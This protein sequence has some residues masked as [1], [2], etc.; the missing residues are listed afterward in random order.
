[1]F[2][3]PA[4]RAETHLKIEA[5]A[6]SLMMYGPAPTIL[7]S[8]SD[9]SQ[10][11][12]IQ[13]ATDASVVYSEVIAFG[14]LA[15]GEHVAFRR[16]HTDLSVSV[17]GAPVYH[18]RFVLC[19]GSGAALEGELAGHGVMGTLV[20]ISGD[21]GLVAYVRHGLTRSEIHGGASGLPGGV[22]CIVKVL[23][24]TLQ[25][26]TQ[27]LQNIAASISCRAVKRPEP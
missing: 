22:G 24:P 20:C 26:L 4:G 10:S 8:G 27:V 12:R 25:A 14:R 23:G 2:E 18:E 17:G 15:R 3:M 9:F 21:S 5:E 1:V 11:T 19:P 16:F 6:G 13:A 7:Q